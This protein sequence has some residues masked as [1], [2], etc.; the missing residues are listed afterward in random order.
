MALEE[1]NNPSN[2][3]EEMKAHQHHH[4]KHLTIETMHAWAQLINFRNIKQVAHTVW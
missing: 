4:S 1:K 3:N 2:V